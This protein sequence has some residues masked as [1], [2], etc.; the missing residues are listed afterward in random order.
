MAASKA[1]NGRNLASKPT[2]TA[3]KTYFVCYNALS[4]VLWAT[5]AVRLVFL[6]ARLVPT[7]HVAHIFDALFPL[8]LFT[9]SLALLEILHAVVKL[10]RA[11]PLAAA[12]QV[13][14]RI[15]VVWPVMF[16]F[17]V[18]RI[19]KEK[20]VV[21]ATSTEPGW[22]LGDWMVVGCLVPWCIT[23]CIRYGY[24]VLQALGATAPQWLLWLRYNTFF[25]LYPIGI[26]SECTLIYKAITPA[27]DIH[28][29]VAWFFIICLVIYVP[30]SFILYTHMMAQRRK[31]LKASKKAD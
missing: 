2:S 3:T 10:V 25:V 5:I 8:L 7:G 15:L 20:A 29:L 4:F 14:S 22:K 26:T 24:F 28:P 23:E 16:F 19:G 21:G 18:D 12:L 30:G 11:S 9:Q 13:L 1:P 17:S 6:L 27:W 31:V